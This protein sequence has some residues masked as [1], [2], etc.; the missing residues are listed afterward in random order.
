MKKRIEFKTSASSITKTFEVKKGTIYIPS[1]DMELIVKKLGFPEKT[2][3][4]VFADGHPEKLNF[5]MPDGRS[6][7]CFYIV[8]SK[9]VDFGG[10][11]N[12]FKK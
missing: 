6:T 1:K 12:K 7:E 9:A 4:K 3:L 11:K 8:L 5:G 10:W 2:A